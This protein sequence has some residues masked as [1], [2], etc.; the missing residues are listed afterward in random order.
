MHTQTHIQIQV[1]C[2]HSICT[3]LELP[4]YPS[5]QLSFSAR[6]NKKQAVQHEKKNQLTLGKEKI[7]KLKEKKIANFSVW[8][9][10]PEIIGCQE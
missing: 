6:K 7:E 2:C 9:G 5:L 4:F 1:H 10:W 8:V 3:S